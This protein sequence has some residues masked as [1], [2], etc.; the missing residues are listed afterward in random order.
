MNHDLLFRLE[1][2][3]RTA[4]LEPGLAARLYDPAWTLGRQWVL[5]EFEGE[6]CGTPVLAEVSL[7]RHRFAAVRAS[8][9]SVPFDPQTTILD[10]IVEALPATPDWTLAERVDAGQA[11]T[12]DL[13]GAGMADE[14]RKLLADFPLIAPTRLA[15]DPDVQALWTLAR[16][17][18]PDG[19]IIAEKVN[20]DPGAF[21]WGGPGKDIVS[22]WLDTLPRRDLPS[23][24]DPARLE[25][26]FAVDLPSLGDDLV[27]EN[28]AGRGLDWHSFSRV[29]SGSPSRTPEALNLERVPTAVTFAG[30]PEPRYWMAEG[31]QVE[32]GAVEADPTDLARM[33]ML[34][35]AFVYGNDAF[36][37]PFPIDPGTLTEVTALSVRDTFGVVTVIGPAARPGAAHRGGFAFL[38]VDPAQGPRS[39]GLVLAG[40]A[41]SALAGPALEDVLLMRDEMANLVWAVERTTEGELGTAVARPEA[42]ARS[43]TARSRHEGPADSYRLRSE[44]PANWFPMSL[45]PGLVRLLQLDRLS[46]APDPAGLL[47]PRPG[48]AIHEG[49]VHREGLVLCRRPVMTRAP[50]GRRLLWFRAE[51]SPG[52]GEGGSGLGYDQL[53]Q[54]D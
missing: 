4:S 33:A 37:M 17:R 47:L 51:R 3:S 46:G 14:A 29:R 41:Q 27:A 2:R 7:A 8:G 44:V 20:G 5:G 22:R 34:Q 16:G 30:M 36:L 12:A 18:V 35:F 48:Q 32:F 25:Y 1:P 9:M 21:G 45:R 52:R 42:L 49:E 10:A 39:P 23:A 6:D 38:S 24:W 15:E 26:G 50:D 43:A 53:V 31:R 40:M 54:D 28:Y 11:L 19:Q 13:A